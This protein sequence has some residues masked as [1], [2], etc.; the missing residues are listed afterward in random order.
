[1]GSSE[2]EHFSTPAVSESSLITSI[3]KKPIESIKTA[4]ACS[5]VSPETVYLV[6]SDNV[7]KEDEVYL[8]L[9]RS[10]KNIE[11]MLK[12]E[13]KSLETF[14]QFTATFAPNEQFTFLSVDTL[15]DEFVIIDPHPSCQYK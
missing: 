7:S 6:D 11:T 1:M 12:V 8:Q 5:F 9:V 15:P 4:Y 13:I 3:H 10:S 14:E 2:E